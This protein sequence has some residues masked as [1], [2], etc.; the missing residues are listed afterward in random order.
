MRCS[1]QKR[2][3]QRALLQT[4][5]KEII[6]QRLGQEFN[7][8]VSSEGGSL[9][10]CREGREDRRGRG[11]K[12]ARFHTLQLQAFGEDVTHPMSGPKR[13]GFILWVY[14]SGK[15]LPPMESHAERVVDRELRGGLMGLALG[16]GGQDSQGGMR[17]RKT[18][19]S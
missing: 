2:A 18:T 7:S 4:K 16:V 8:L 12:P 5:T 14:L 17:G 9:R 3:D 11:L 15:E 1:S 19:A 13:Q 6:C 10:Q